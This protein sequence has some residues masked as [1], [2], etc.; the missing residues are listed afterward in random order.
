MA[1]LAPTDVAPFSVFK[2]LFRPSA[3]TLALT[4]ALVSNPRLAHADSVT[5][6][7]SVAPVSGS[8][9]RYTYQL[10]GT[11][12]ANDD[13]AIMFPAGSS[14]SLSVSADSGSAFS[15]FVLQPD[16][17][18]PADGEF[19]II[20]LIS[21]PDLSTTFTADFLYS[22]TD[23]PLSQAFTLYS[24]DYSALQTGITQAA[25]TV[26]MAPEPT[27]LSLLAT[28][29]VGLSVAQRKRARSR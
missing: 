13:L 9:Y 25:D 28:G 26:A 4:A 5:V 2:R 10:S 19:D 7:Y 14:S 27:S 1:Y 17:A 8:V 18:I 24:S 21:N 12:S 23:A 22:G 15:T 11:L 20:S 16:A 3:L 6:S 29:L